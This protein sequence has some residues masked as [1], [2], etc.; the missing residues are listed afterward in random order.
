MA[1]SQETLDQATAMIMVASKMFSQASILIGFIT[2]GVDPTP[3]QLAEQ[4]DRT[5]RLEN[6]WNSLAPAEL[7]IVEP[8]PDVEEETTDAD[9]PVNDVLET[10]DIKPTSDDDEDNNNDDP[11]DGTAP[12]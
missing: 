1:V 10:T 3:E 2:D 7:E 5:Q 6:Q 12:V 9:P 4:R 8:V 11:P